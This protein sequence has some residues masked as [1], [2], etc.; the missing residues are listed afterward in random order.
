MIF[1]GRVGVDVGKALVGI[2]VGSFVMT[3]GDTVGI[4]V[5]LL[6]ATIGDK[7]GS[8]VGSLVITTGAK[9]GLFVGSLVLGVG[10]GIVTF[11]GTSPSIGLAV[12]QKV[13][14]SID[15]VLLCAPFG[16]SETGTVDAMEISAKHPTSRAVESKMTNFIVVEALVIQEGTQERPVVSS[17]SL[18]SCV[19]SI[20]ETTLFESLPA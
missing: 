17:S 20:G 18:E 1:V 9:V 5:G 8:F 7:V 19:S 10:T 13:L 11:V 4:S 14:Y 3:I 2:F 16:L 6:V 12:G 15:S